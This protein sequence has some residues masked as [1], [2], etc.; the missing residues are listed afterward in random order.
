[1]KGGNGMTYQKPELKKIEADVKVAQHAGDQSSCHGG[2]C[3]ES[4]YENDH[5]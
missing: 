5:P 1:M 3:V 4:I 2:H